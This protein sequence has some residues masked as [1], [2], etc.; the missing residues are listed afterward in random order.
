MCVELFWLDRI[1]KKLDNLFSFELSVR[2]KD[3]AINPT[4]HDD[5]GL[6]APPEIIISVI[7]CARRYFS[8]SRCGHFGQNV[9]QKSSARTEDNGKIDIGGHDDAPPRLAIE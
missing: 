9:K 7:Y 8:A 3:D 6:H 4:Q 2:R 1:F 5:D